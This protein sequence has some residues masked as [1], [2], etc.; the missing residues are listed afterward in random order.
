VAGNSDSTSEIKKIEIAT[1]WELL[2]T[3]GNFWELLGTFPKISEN[4]CNFPMAVRPC[5]NLDDTENAMIWLSQS[6]SLSRHIK[7]HNDPSDPHHLDEHQTLCLGFQFKDG[8]V[9]MCQSTPHMMLN[10]ARMTNC[11]WQKQIHV[12][13]AFNFCVKDFS[14]VSIGCNSMEAHFKP[15]S[16]N[17]VNSESRDA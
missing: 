4:S 9:F 1:N 7:K 17:I 15:I 12:D 5:I 10:L 14:M 11:R 2:G 3:F 8:I 6:L 13:G 16:L